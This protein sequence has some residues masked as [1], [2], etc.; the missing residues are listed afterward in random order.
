MEKLQ[1]NLNTSHLDEMLNLSP[2]RRDEIDAK[3]ETRIENALRVA[4][5]NGRPGVDAFTIIKRCLLIAETENELAYVAF[6][7]G[8]LKEKNEQQHEK[9]RHM[10]MIEPFIEMIKTDIEQEAKKKDED[11][12]S[13]LN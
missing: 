11:A 5:E 2:A 8:V 6:H 9:R 1:L 13:S 3:M 4:K 7:L 12:K 10:K